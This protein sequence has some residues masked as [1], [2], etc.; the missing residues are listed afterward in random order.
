[1]FRQRSDLQA[2]LMRILFSRIANALRSLLTSKGKLALPAPPVVSESLPAPGP[3]AL[4]MV[5]EATLEIGKG[6]EGANNSGAVV[7]KYFSGHRDEPWCAAFVSW[8]ARRAAARCH[9]KVPF[10]QST[11]AKRLFRNILK[12]HGAL[13]VKEPLRGDIICWH[14]G[15][16]GSWQGHIGIVASVGED[17]LVRC[18]EGNVG[19]FPARVAIITHDLSH[20]RVVGIARLTLHAV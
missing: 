20:E 17:G 4:S 5:Y 13:L 19:K 2:R 18:V 3:F 14:R 12:T 10:V 15:K 9:G 1:M 16:D 11:S 6:E 7:H 8:C